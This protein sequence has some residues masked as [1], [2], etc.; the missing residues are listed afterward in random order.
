MGLH[1]RPLVLYKLQYNIAGVTKQFI[2]QKARIILDVQLV[3]EQDLFGGGTNV[4]RS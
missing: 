4:S 1:Q 3:I 2:F